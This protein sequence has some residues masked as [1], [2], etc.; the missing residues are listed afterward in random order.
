MGGR[1]IMTWLANLSQRDRRALLLLVPSIAVIAALYF[2]IPMLDAAGDSARSIESREKLLH[3]YQ[4]V[5]AVVPAHETNAAAL[6]DALAAAERGLLSG[7]TPALQVAEVQQMVRDLAS[8][9][10]IVVH[11]SEE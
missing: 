10:G 1:Q 11:R 3:K 8:A 5:A 7:A 4:A 9:Q 2:A 6:N